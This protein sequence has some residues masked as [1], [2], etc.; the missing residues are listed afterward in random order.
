MIS[1]QGDVGEP[2]VAVGVVGLG[3]RHVDP[4]DDGRVDRERAVGVLEV[5]VA[6]A[7]GRGQQRIA[8]DRVHDRVEVRG[9]GQRAVLPA[10][11]VVGEAHRDDEVVDAARAE[12]E[13][14]RRG[15][16]RSDARARAG[17]RVRA[18]AARSARRSVR[19]LRHGHEAEC[20]RVAAAGEVLGRDEPPVRRTPRPHP[21]AAVGQHREAV[22][23]LEPVVPRVAVAAQHE[24]R[25]V[26]LHGLERS[27]PDR[28]HALG[29][30]G[31]I[32]GLGEHGRT[33]A[34]ERHEQGLLEHDLLLWRRG[35]TEPGL[36]RP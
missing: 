16:R 11:P 23:V 5:V 27:G 7:A 10:G 18:D 28:H 3:V 34:R 36:D 33:G 24:R 13:D 15:P 25:A 17:R 4:G 31:R 30:R 35:A 22:L 1:S 29:P 6:H 2:V 14:A 12:A 32:G 9:A 19:A 20:A 21:A 26:G 8:A